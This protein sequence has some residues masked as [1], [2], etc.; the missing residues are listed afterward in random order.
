MVIA[1]ESAEGEHF[2]GGARL[3]NMVVITPNGPEVIDHYPSDE[4]IV[5][6]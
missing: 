3:E 1:Y 2:V 6:D 5:I 4:I